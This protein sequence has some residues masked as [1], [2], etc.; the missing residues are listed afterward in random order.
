MV[1]VKPTKDPTEIKFSVMEITAKLLSHCKKYAQE[2]CGVQKISNVVL[3]VPG[4][5]THA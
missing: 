3:T 1:V 4:N 5:F 2:H